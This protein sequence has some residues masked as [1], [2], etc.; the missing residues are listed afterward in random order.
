MYDSGIWVPTGTN[1]DSIKFLRVLGWQTL[2]N[3][4]HW[5]FSFTLDDSKWGLYNY[6]IIPV[7]YLQFLSVD[8]TQ[9]P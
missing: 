1:F 8:V 9:N 5:I 3:K 4:L 2:N 7:G 6:G